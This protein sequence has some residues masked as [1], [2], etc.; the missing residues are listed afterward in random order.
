MFS[1]ILSIYAHSQTCHASDNLFM[2]TTEK[3]NPSSKDFGVGKTTV[4][5]L[6]WN[7]YKLLDKHVRVIT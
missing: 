1:S 3:L 5:A 7:M 2:Y 4:I 6:H